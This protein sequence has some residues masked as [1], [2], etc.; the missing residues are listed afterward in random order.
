MAEL[1]LHDSHVHLDFD[2]FEKDRADVIQRSKQNGIKHFVVPGVCQKY[3]CR[4][5]QLAA[6]E[7]AVLPALGI[8]P[9]YLDDFHQQHLDELT[10]LLT[11]EQQLVAVGEIGLDWVIQT[12]R[13]VQIAVFEQ[14][15]DI[16]KQFN[17][18]VIIHH[19]RSHD[20]IAKILRQ[21]QLAKAGVIHGFSGSLQQANAYIELGFKLGVGG[22]ITYPRAEKTRKVIKKVPIESLLLETDA[23]DMP[24][25]G[26]QG[27]RNSPEYITEV[28]QALIELRRADPALLSVQLAKNF[29]QTFSVAVAA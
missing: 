2:D 1:T 14:Q 16:A 6:I 20:E 21:K 25:F 3:W 28:F 12:D 4:L 19:R 23:P 11:N 17:K 8:H 22:T 24:L 18:P 5:L 13:K 27:K 7:Q 9:W 29:S 15:L 26:K 10:R